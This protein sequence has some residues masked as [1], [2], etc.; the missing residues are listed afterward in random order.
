MRTDKA[1]QIPVVVTT[2]LLQ[3]SS[4]VARRACSGPEIAM[5]LQHVS[6]S[7]RWRE[8]WLMAQACGVAVQHVELAEVNLLALAL[9]A[10]LMLFD[11][12]KLALR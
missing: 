11:P 7:V 1:V 2:S 4:V 6:L 12:A 5:R 8:E 10:C 9:A 3:L